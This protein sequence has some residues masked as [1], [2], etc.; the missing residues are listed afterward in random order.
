MSIYQE[1]DTIAW[2][3]DEYE[4]YEVKSPFLVCFKII[5][6]N[7][8]PY[9]SLNETMVPED[10]ATIVWRVW[11]SY[12]VVQCYDQFGHFDPNSEWNVFATSHWK[13]PFKTEIEAILELNKC[14]F[15]GYIQRLA[16]YRSGSTLTAGTTYERTR[17]HGHTNVDY[18]GAQ[19]E[20]LGIIPEGKRYFSVKFGLY[21]S[22]TINFTDGSS[23]PIPREYFD[24][25]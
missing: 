22:G 18:R 23:M 11:Y 14:T 13:K 25:K 5:P 8:Y 21:P 6:N 12:Q 17:K 16:N 4:V 20:S 3:D 1:R 15:P 7:G 24:L 9:T 19:F 10:Q 2:M